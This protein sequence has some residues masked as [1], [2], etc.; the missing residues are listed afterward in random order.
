MKFGVIVTCLFAITHLC[1]AI[2]IQ[3]QLKAET[4]RAIMLY[5]ASVTGTVFMHTTQFH[6]MPA[7]ALYKPT[8]C[9][10]SNFASLV[11]TMFFNDV[12]TFCVVAPELAEASHATTAGCVTPTDGIYRIGKSYFMRRQQD[13]PKEFFTTITTDGITQWL[14]VGAVPF[15]DRYGEE[16][17][18]I[19]PNYPFLQA[20]ALR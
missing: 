6:D 16:L 20:I 9:L 14:Q 18:A 2:Y 8:T 11:F 19:Y 15:V 13:V 12:R 3:K 17:Y 7:M 5:K 4:E 1:V 10:K